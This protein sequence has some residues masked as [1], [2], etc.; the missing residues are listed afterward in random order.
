MILHTFFFFK[1]FLHTFFLTT[2]NFSNLISINILRYRMDNFINDFIKELNKRLPKVISQVVFDYLDPS[3]IPSY[4]YYTFSFKSTR[5]ILEKKY[6][7]YG[8]FKIIQYRLYWLAYLGNIPQMEYDYKQLLNN[9]N[10]YKNKI[11]I[12]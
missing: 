3:F 8:Q 2:L 7:K 4:E 11:H 12:I 9:N 10:Y 5:K 6:H 1:L